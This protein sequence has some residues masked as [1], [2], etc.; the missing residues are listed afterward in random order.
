MRAGDRLTVV[1]V[2]DHDPELLRYLGSMGL[3]PGTEI[4]LLA[5]APFD[6]PLTL[7]IGENQHNLG[8][9]AAKAVMV[10]LQNEK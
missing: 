6:G 9:Q 7:S 4:C 5:Y 10:I 2:D 8:Y 3:Y 1:E